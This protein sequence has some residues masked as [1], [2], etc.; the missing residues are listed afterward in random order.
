M[1]GGMHAGV[2]VSLDAEGECVAAPLLAG[3]A[4]WVARRALAAGS[5]ARLLPP[6]RPCA[7]P[8]CAAP[9]LHGV[10]VLAI[11]LLGLGVAGKALL[12][13]GGGAVARCSVKAV[14]GPK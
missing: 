2:W 3:A 8:R 14:L 7:A 12:R 10:L 6:L 11:A 4:V 1:G 9:V 13:R 5:G